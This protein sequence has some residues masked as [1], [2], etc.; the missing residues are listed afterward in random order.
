MKRRIGFVS[1]S[2]SS[3]FVMIVSEEGHRK[4]LKG[5]NVY[6]RDLV[7][8][9]VEEVSTNDIV[10]YVYDDICVQGEHVLWY[11]LDIGWKP[12]YD[13]LEDESV[14]DVM[15]AYKNLLDKEDILYTRHSDF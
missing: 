3:S 15:Y 2:S 14:G 1:N 9:I 13:G 10:V 6:Q 12:E 8:A 11:G 7:S 5:L 4:A